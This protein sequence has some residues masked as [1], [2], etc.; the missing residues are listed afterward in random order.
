MARG[1]P[2]TSA[3]DSL[4]EVSHQPEWLVVTVRPSSYSWPLG[5]TIR[6]TARNALEAGPARAVLIDVREVR[7]KMSTTQRF[8]MGVYAA[9]LRFPGPIA[10]VGHELMVDP[11]H[12]GALVARSRGAHSEAFTVLG[13]AER[14]LARMIARTP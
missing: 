4:I 7:G 12:F 6:R 1:T 3:Y 5:Q 14:W 2:E 10:M 9:A 13:E 8:L 11:E